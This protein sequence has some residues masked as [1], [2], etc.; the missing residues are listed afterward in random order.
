MGRLTWLLPTALII[1]FAGYLFLGAVP[2]HEEGGFA[3]VSAPASAK[4]SA[5]PSVASRPSG[6]AS[7]S[8]VRAAV[9]RPRVMASKPSVHASAA[10]HPIGAASPVVLLPSLVGNPKRPPGQV[11]KAAPPAMALLHLPAMAL[12]HLPSMLPAVTIHV[13]ILM[14]HHVSSAPPATELNYG[15]TV[16]DQ[17]FTAQLTYLHDHGYHTVTELQIFNA[18]YR[19]KPLPAKPVMLTFDDGYRDNYTD[20]LPI[21][22]RF[23]DHGEFNII[24][25]YVG[26][27]L[28]VNSYMTW[29]QLRALVAADMDIGSHT[30]DHQDL[31]TLSEDKVRFELRDSRNVLQQKLHVSVQWLAYPSGQPFAS[32]SV[33]AQQLLLTLLP[34]YGYVGALLD[35]PLTTSLQNAQT[36][37]QLERIRVS[38]GEGLAGY[39][40]SLSA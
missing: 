9:S 28:G 40:A 25:A 35:G 39:I 14:Y 13:P 38:G 22:K 15:L 1:A 3:A 20:A 33:A 24:S 30:V 11:L 19:H 4:S 27:T 12:L 21:L 32:E 37:Y 18:L 2:S 8:G 5:R 36:P 23:H 29:P 6:A 7:N 26:T 17:D 31:G 16:T 34:Q 10:T